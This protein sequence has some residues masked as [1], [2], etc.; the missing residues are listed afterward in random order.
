MQGWGGRGRLPEFLLHNSERQDS[1]SPQ[2]VRRYMPPDEGPPRRVQSLA[3][4]GIEDLQQQGSQQLFFRNNRS[5]AHPANLMV[6]I[7]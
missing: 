6:E 4:H 7:R 3:S 2:T 5:A 1:P